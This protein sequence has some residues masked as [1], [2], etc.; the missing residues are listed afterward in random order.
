MCVYLHLMAWW[1]VLQSKKKLRSQTSAPLYRT[2]P[3]L[4]PEETQARNTETPQEREKGQITIYITNTLFLFSGLSV[5]MHK[6]RSIK[7]LR[8]RDFFFNHIFCVQLFCPLDMPSGKLLFPV[9]YGQTWRR[10]KT[11]RFWTI[12][13][14]IVFCLP[15][16]FKSIRQMPFFW[17]CVQ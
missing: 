2:P 16:K 3:Q 11:I 6:S 9:S 14:F 15:P 12:R 8:L 13:F 5:L 7:R 10:S 4:D 1:Q 17:M